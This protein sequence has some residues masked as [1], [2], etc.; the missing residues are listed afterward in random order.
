MEDDKKKKKTK[1][2][3]IDDHLITSSPPKANKKKKKKT[4]DAAA[5]VVVPAGNASTA[6][7]KIEKSKYGFR[8]LTLK[9]IGPYHTSDINK[10]SYL[11]FLIHSSKQEWIRVNRESF[12]ITVFG[13]YKAEAAHIIAGDPATA[14]ETRSLLAKNSR[15]QI[16]LDPA[17]MG[18]GF[19]TRVE[20]SIN[21]VPVPT[22][23][24]IGSH[25]GQYA[26][27][28]AIYNTDS[29]KVYFALASDVDFT[30]GRDAMSAVMKRA[31]EAFDYET[32]DSQ[33]GT[34]IPIPM[35][36]IFP[37]DCKNRT[38]QSIDKKMK[39]TLTAAAGIDDDD[40]GI[41]LP[42]DTIL[43][44]KLHLNKSVIDSIFHQHVEIT[45]NY[46][47]DTPIA[48]DVIAARE[49]KLTFRDVTLQ[50][51]SGEMRPS[52]HIDTMRKFTSG[53]AA[54]IY[55]YD[56]A[57]GQHQALSSGQ[58]FTE[59][60]FQILPFSRLIYISFC[61]DWATFPM[62]TQRK[63]LSGFS[64]FPTGARSIQIGF[65]GEDSLVMKKFNYFGTN[66]H[67]GDITKKGWFEHLIKGRMFRG[68]FGDIFPRKAGDISLVQT[69]VFDLK[70]NMSDKMEHLKITCLFS[71]TTSP[72]HVQIVVISVHPNGKAT[73]KKVANQAD[74]FWE[75]SP[76][77]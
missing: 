52:D 62:E 28:C 7:E 70:A 41:F 63:P 74:W 42:P 58:S 18:A 43:E 26:H 40:N 48:A 61:Q 20:V 9:W 38:I 47:T 1:K 27:V 65:G 14:A 75:F 33:E 30:K 69:F 11:H 2:R 21:N 13:T 37:F 19:F 54:A 44:V 66:A 17:I 73:C 23:G 55:T 15:P 4:S 64:R 12:T 46:W 10:E 39:K 77:S 8:T 29:S 50:Y 49:L 36:G 56:I 35:N 53:S 67:N 59:N 6:A 57:R 60:H 3:K 16:Y 31:T 72:Q 71:G 25:F 76:S 51:D 68:K 45:G 24:A 22:N 34:R 32:H 5:P